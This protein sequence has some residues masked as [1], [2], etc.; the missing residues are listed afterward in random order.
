MRDERLI[1]QAEWEVLRTKVLDALV[2]RASGSSI[3]G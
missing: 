3:T 1:T 2:A